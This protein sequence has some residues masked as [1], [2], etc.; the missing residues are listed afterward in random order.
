MVFEEVDVKEGRFWNKM[1]EVW[2]T[3]PEALILDV[4]V[5]CLSLPFSSQCILFGFFGVEL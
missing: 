1:I 2:K 4:R 3:W 5:L